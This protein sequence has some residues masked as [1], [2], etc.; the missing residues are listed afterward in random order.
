MHVHVAGVRSEA[1]TSLGLVAFVARGAARN[2]LA[3]Y[4]LPLEEPFNPRASQ[5]EAA[6][7]RL[8][9]REGSFVGR[10]R[11]WGRLNDART[12]SCLSA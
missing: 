12:E 7:T 4:T 11:S 1:A 10:P 8:D 6:A 3:K 5:V 2:S 9:A